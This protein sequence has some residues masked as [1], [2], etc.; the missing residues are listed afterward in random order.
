M[1]TVLH[2][3]VPRPQGKQ[4]VC[5]QGWKASDAVH[6]ELQLQCLAAEAVAGVVAGTAKVEL[7]LYHTT[8]SNTA[9]IH[10]YNTR[11]HT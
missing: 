7:L 3:A 5:S 4:R 8:T 10:T 2:P 6:C 11:I 9:I 1:A